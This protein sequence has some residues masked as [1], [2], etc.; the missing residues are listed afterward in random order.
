MLSICRI[1]LHGTKMEIL[2]IFLKIC[3]I[4]K[5]NDITFIILPHFA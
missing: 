4:E 5:L 2:I 1:N 3:V